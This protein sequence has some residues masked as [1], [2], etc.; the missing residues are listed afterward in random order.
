MRGGLLV[1][2]AAIGTSVAVSAALMPAD[3]APARKAAPARVA[4]QDWTRTVAVTPE[5]GY[6]MGNPAAPVKLVEYGSLTCSHCADFAAQAGEPLRAKVRTGK[7]S[8]EFRNYV[9]NGIDVTASLLAR[10]AAPAQFFPLTDRLFAA[11]AQWIGRISGLS[12]AEKDKLKAMPESQR[13]GR[14]ADLGG[15]TQMAAGAGV[16][17]ARGK[18]CLADR[19]GLDRLESMAEAA[20]ALGVTGTPTFF[21]NGANIG[22]HDWASLEPVIRQAGG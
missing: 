3:A 13:L 10:C 14:I 11:Q 22:T 16:T 15:L 4:G 19:A 2:L 12:Q 8:Y 17:P 9:L 1:G 5:G 6:R 20:S 18:A 7:V 21:L